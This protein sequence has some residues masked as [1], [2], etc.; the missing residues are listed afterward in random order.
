MFD[1]QNTE[2]NCFLPKKPKT[3]PV[4]Q[5]LTPREQLIFNEITSK[6][7]FEA[8]LNELQNSFAQILSEYGCKISGRVIDTA[9][10]K[11][12]KTHSAFYYIDHSTR[13]TKY[14]DASDF[15]EYS[16]NHPQHDVRLFCLRSA[17]KL[18][19]SRYTKTFFDMFGRGKLY[20][21]KGKSFS[22]CRI[23][24]YMWA[25]ENHVFEYLK[26]HYKTISQ[27]QKEDQRLQKVF[28]NQKKRGVCRKQKFRNIHLEAVF[29]P[30][31]RKNSKFQNG[32]QSTHEFL[33]RKW[34]FRPRRKDG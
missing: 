24:Y 15:E 7:Q 4:A 5:E 3:K 22:L 9:M 6:P 14:V 2:W 20:T 17:Y 10:T 26:R 21:Y 25:K 23:N 16:K 18:Q 32:P 34:S 30:F 13:P 31:C 27:L 28:R 8:C 12:S 11:Y 1:L 19:M 33:G 29:K